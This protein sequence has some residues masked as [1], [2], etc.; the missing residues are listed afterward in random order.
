MKG[1]NLR[2]V[3]GVGEGEGGEGERLPCSRCSRVS[4]HA[5]A[6]GRA[7]TSLGSEIGT[8]QGTGKS[9][10]ASEE[11]RCRARAGGSLF[12][13]GMEGQRVRT[14]GLTKACDGVD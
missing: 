1:L 2:G 7:R 10:S 6:S 9:K 3:A 11:G 14:M 5:A 4:A 12:L 8:L 13:P